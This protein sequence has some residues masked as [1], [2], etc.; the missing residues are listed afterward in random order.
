MK[1]LL[2]FDYEF[3]EKEPNMMQSKLKLSLAFVFILIG[4]YIVISCGKNEEPSINYSWV[5]VGYQLKM[6]SNFNEVGGWINIFFIDEQIGFL[7][8]R[9][10][11]GFSF[12]RTDNGCTSFTDISNQIDG[13][14][15][16]IVFPDDQTGYL[17]TRHFTSPSNTYNSLYKTSDKGKNWIKVEIDAFYDEIVQVGSNSPENV[18]IICYE[19][20]AFLYSNDGG[21]SWSIYNID[22]NPIRKFEEVKFQFLKDDPNIGFFNNMQTIYKTIDG[23]IS[24]DNY[25]EYGHE[26]F[27]FIDISTA[28]ISNTSGI[29][30]TID[31][32][33][34]FQQLASFSPRL[35]Q[36]VSDHEIYVAQVYNIQRTFNEFQNLEEMETST[37]SDNKIDKYIRDISF[38][39]SKKGYAISG[40]GIV[41]KTAE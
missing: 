19:P 34:S 6:S 15:K 38:Y 32:G 24:W 5:P 40:N 31:G 18:F 35:W 30:K 23:G 9:E 21:D 2:I 39:E 14:A 25:F 33:S 29:F 28:Y 11:D 17:V 1:F 10:N 20:N 26:N 37:P 41:Y 8:H 13:Y 16:E 12:F 4:V 27:W 22:L 3:L 7:S 36:I